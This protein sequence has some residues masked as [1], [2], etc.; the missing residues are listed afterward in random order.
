MATTRSSSDGDEVDRLGVEPVA[1]GR[2][3]N[4]LLADEHPIAQVER[5]VD[6]LGRC[7]VGRTSI[8]PGSIAV[9]FP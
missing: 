3:L 2:P 8:T 7:G 6:L 1:V 5:G 4:A 9:R